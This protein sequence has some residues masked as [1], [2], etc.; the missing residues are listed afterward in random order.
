MQE[1]KMPPYLLPT[2]LAASGIALLFADLPYSL[3]DWRFFVSA[4]RHP[5]APYQ[6]MEIFNPPWVM[7]FTWPLSLPALISPDVSLFVARLVIV[8]VFAVFVLQRGGDWKAVLLVLTS[9]PVLNQ[10]VNANVD[11]LLAIALIPGADRR[12]GLPLL[13]LKP[14][15]GAGVALLW[16][17]EAWEEN[18][19]AGALNLATLT[20]VIFAASFL[21]Y[22][23]WP[24]ELFESAILSRQPW[25]LSIFPYGVPLGMVLLWLALRW[26]DDATALAAMLLLSPYF[27]FHSL[28]VLFAAI[29]LRFSD[30]RLRLAAWAV[31]WGLFVL[32]RLG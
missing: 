1:T 25:N 8:F 9:A 14:Q 17:K 24:S 11:W 32:Q 19:L 15:T 4:A 31:F 13:L 22:G 23:F 21:F 3:S 18:R 16:L 30:N 26:K 10:V 12:F 6:V 29:L 5:F 27:A 28:A 2:L 20:G 7:W